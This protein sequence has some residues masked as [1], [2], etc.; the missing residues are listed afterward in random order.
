MQLFLTFCDNN[1]DCIGTFP[2]HIQSA[3]KQYEHNMNIVASEK[4]FTDAKQRL[5]EIITNISL[6]KTI[7]AKTL[8]FVG[9]LTFM[10]HNMY[11]KNNKAYCFDI[12]DA[13]SLFPV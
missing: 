1:L 10:Y 5:N 2:G 4:D 6:L 3:I 12:S 11:Y 13:N 7:N 9:G 8:H